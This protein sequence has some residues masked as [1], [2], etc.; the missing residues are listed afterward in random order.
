MKQKNIDLR[1]CGIANSRGMVTSTLGVPLE[2]WR[3]ALAAAEEPFNLGR[4][5]RLVK[6]FHLL[7]PV[8]VDC[9]SSEEVASQYADFLPTA[10]TW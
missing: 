8:I 9:T 10:S 2:N 5:I 6:E 3:E 7:N 1:V 4:L